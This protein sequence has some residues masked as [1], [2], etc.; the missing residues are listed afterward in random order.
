M[1][2]DGKVVGF[3]FGFDVVW[4]VNFADLPEVEPQSC[5]PHLYTPLTRDFRSALCMNFFYA[6]CIFARLIHLD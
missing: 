3:R 6:C 2:L 4:K 5:S 1:L